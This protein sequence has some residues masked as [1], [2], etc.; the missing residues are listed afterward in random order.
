MRYYAYGSNLCSRYLKEYCPSAVFVTKADLPNYRIEFRRYSH[1]MGGGISTI[2]EA[3]GRLI[4]G[5]I[6][7]V[8]EGEI[9]AMDKLEGVPEGLYLRETFLVLGADC[10]WHRADLY[11]IAKPEGPHAP[12]KRYVDLMVEG[13]R[14]HGLDPKYVAELSALRRSLG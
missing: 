13:A 11:R 14:E 2:M 4:R 1:G 10:N 9:G 3:P 7:E 6:Y 8:P 12:A 5:V